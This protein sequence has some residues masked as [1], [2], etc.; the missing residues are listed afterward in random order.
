MVAKLVNC[1]SASEI[2]SI[3]ILEKLKMNKIVFDNAH[4]FRSG[5]EG[6]ESIFMN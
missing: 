1:N 2:N 3:N 6:Y 4:A 5:G